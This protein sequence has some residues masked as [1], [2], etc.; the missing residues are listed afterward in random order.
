MQIKKIAAYSFE[1]LSESSQSRAVGKFLAYSDFPWWS[2]CEKALRSFCDH[3]GVGGLDYSI[4]AYCPS[5][6]SSKADN[7][8]FKG[9]KLKHFKDA[10]KLSKTGYCE[11]IYMFEQFYAEWERT[12]SALL[13]FNHALWQGCF[14]IQKDMEYFHSEE[15]A[16]E[17]LINNE[18]LFTE[19][20]EMFD[21]K[22]FESEAA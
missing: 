12:G 6:I 17:E 18:H 7:S 15:Y 4:G 3:F 14:S 9:L 1:E 21:Y 8:H 13:A 20:G 22:Y 19:D 16:R 2:D 10:E 11:E 5:H